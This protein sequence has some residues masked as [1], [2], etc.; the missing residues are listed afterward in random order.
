MALFE[1]VASFEFNRPPI[2][3]RIAA[4]ITAPPSAL[5]GD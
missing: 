1:K 3:K 5:I 4:A 2:I